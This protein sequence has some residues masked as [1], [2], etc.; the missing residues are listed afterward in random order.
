MKVTVK[1]GTVEIELKSGA[2]TADSPT[3]L[4]VTNSPAHIDEAHLP[5]LFEAF[6]RADTQ[7]TSGS[8]LGLYITGMVLSMFDAEYGI[9]NTGDGVEFRI[10][11]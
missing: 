1:G 9:R 3:T 11:Q 10:T 8:G 7:Y 4:I 6:Y 2:G 5:H